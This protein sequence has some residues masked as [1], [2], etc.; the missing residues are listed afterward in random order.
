MNRPAVA[1]VR[2]ALLLALAVFMP[3]LF[4]AAGGLG[5]VL[6][7]MHLPVLVGALVLPLPWS[8]AVGAAAPLLSSFLFGMPPPPL[9]GLMACELAAMAAVLHVASR[10]MTSLYAALGLAMVAGRMV[11][12]AASWGLVRVFGLPLDM[13]AVFT[14]VFV[15]GLPGMVL[16]LALLPPL[17]SRLASRMST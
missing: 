10:R 12:I 5:A 2:A 14:A 16:Q 13:G 6:L 7:P 11:R 15:T 8:L 4:H 1:L 17:A 3:Q 9:H